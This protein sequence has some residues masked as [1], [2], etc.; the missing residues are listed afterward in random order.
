V[1]SSAGG[2]S[3]KFGR[4]AAYLV[5]MGYDPETRVVEETFYL[6]RDPLLSPQT[7]QRPVGATDRA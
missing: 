2:V 1:S 3:A 4:A 6:A 5:Q 7:A